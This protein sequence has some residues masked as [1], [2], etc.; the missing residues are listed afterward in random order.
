M[1]PAYDREKWVELYEKVIFEL[2]HAKM[3]GR[4][5]DTRIELAVR[6]GKLRDAPGLH[7]AELHAI[8]EAYRML[9][10]FEGNEERYASEEKSRAIDEALHK[11]RSIAPKRN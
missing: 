11:L 3:T 5:E 2:E 6:I 9:R 10:V 4:I 8:D 1:S 7:S